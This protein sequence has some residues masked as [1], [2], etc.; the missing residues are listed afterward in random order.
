L[1][2]FLSDSKTN[3]GRSLKLSCW[4]HWKKV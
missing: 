3:A 4:S 2:E 1:R